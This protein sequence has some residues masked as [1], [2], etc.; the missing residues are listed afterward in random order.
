MNCKEFS[1][2]SGMSHVLNYSYAK[3]ECNLSTHSQ[4][5]NQLVSVALA[6]TLGVYVYTPY[7]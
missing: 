1:L 6:V 3:C 2:L 7:L 4:I 5:N